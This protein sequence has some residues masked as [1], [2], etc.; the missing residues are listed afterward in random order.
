MGKSNKFNTAIQEYMNMERD[1]RANELFGKSESLLQIAEVKLL[2]EYM[3]DLKNP[4]W[5]LIL[6]DNNPTVYMISNVGEVYNAVECNMET[7]TID[8][9]GHEYIYITQPNSSD[10]HKLYIHELVADAFIP[11]PENCKQVKHKNNKAVN[12]AGNLEWVNLEDDNTS[13]V[14]KNYANC[15]YSESDV[16]KI[17]K[18]LQ[19]KVVPYTVAKAFNMPA[20]TL[21]NIQNGKTWKHVSSQ[22]NIPRST[23]VKSTAK[24]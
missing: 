17:C 15:K 6:Y 1:K 10:K 12:W 20:G 23:P 14:A 19:D 3:H 18:L 7:L 2:D 22:Y 9:N 16:H 4:Q 11:N 21:W 8:D 5:K 24:K 13:N